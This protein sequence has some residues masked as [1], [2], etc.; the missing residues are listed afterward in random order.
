MLQLCL[1]PLAKSSRLPYLQ[2]VVIT[3][4]SA[5][6]HGRLC[7]QNV[8]STKT[9]PRQ[10]TQ[11]ASTIGN[12][13]QP[14]RFTNLQRNKRTSRN[15]NITIN[16][17]INCVSKAIINLLFP[18]KST[19]TLIESRRMHQ[20]RRQIQVKYIVYTATNDKWIEPTRRDS[21]PDKQK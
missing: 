14:L 4:V 10:K 20:T 21:R 3:K 5:S 16:P 9:N 13:C 2:Y 6:S 19:P 7:H 12:H 1:L 11:R 17:K 8:C 18:I 15:P